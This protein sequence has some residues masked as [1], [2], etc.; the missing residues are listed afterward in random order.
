VKRITEVSYYVRMCPWE[1]SAPQK[2]HLI[3]AR[4]GR[5]VSCPSNLDIE[6]ELCYPKEGIV[7][8]GG[9]KTL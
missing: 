9:G 2:L 3:R 1:F 5:K 7:V 6:K 4:Q 8:S